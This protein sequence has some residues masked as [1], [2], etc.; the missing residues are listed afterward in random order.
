MGEVNTTLCVEARMIGKHLDTLSHAGLVQ[1]QTKG[2]EKQYVFDPHSL[3]TVS[4]WIETI[5]KQW[6][7]RLQRLKDLVE[8]DTVTL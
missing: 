1:A 5:G 8:D 2:R 6:G 3:Q 7:K 4:A